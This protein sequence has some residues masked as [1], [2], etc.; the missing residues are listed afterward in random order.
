MQFYVAYGER[1][2]GWVRKSKLVRAILTPLFNLALKK[3]Q[4]QSWR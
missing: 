4:E 1:I 3:A 2:A